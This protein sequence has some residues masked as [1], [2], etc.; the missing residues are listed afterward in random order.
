[1]TGPLGSAGAGDPGVGDV[2]GRPPREV[3]ELEVYKLKTSMAGPLE[4]LAAWS[5]NG[6]H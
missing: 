1:M 4:V 2:D 5:G 3:P 6:H